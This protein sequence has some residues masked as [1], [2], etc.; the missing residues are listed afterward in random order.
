[1]GLQ[2]VEQQ[3]LEPALEEVP[4]DRH[5]SLEPPLDHLDQ[6]QQIVRRLQR[7]LKVEQTLEADLQEA[8]AEWVEW[9]RVWADMVIKD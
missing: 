8:W 7:D 3:R 2:A 4:L 1:M 6:H 9:A 5:L